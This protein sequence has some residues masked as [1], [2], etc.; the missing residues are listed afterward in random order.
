MQRRQVGILPG[1]FGQ[2][3]VQTQGLAKLENGIS[4]I[5]GQGEIAGEV[6][7]EGSTP[8]GGIVYLLQHR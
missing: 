4:G 2:V 3:G 7:D 8:P 5:P 1:P 6:V